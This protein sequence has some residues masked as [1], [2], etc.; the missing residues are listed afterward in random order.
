MYDGR[1]DKLELYLALKD[2]AWLSKEAFR[3][4]TKEG[5]TDT[6]DSFMKA[7][8]WMDPFNDVVDYV[9][10]PPKKHIHVLVVRPEG[11]V[12]AVSAVPTFVGARS[13]FITGMGTRLP[14]DNIDTTKPYLKRGKLLSSLIE[15]VQLERVVLLASPAGS[16]KSSLL[17]LFYTE[18]QHEVDIIWI[19]CRT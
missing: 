3:E 12:S 4:I 19:D 7:I 1:A 15:L 8:N 16:G 6:L 17:T 2:G 5:S 10:N 13:Q 9:V 18:V 14:Y 11:A